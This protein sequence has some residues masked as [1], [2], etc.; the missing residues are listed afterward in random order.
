MTS[1]AWYAYLA[2]E[3]I[4]CTLRASGQSGWARRREMISRYGFRKIAGADC[5]NEGILGTA[6]F[7]VSD[8]ADFPSAVRDKAEEVIDSMVEAYEKGNGCRLR[9]ADLCL[10]ARVEVFRSRE[11]I[12]ISSIEAVIVGECGGEE[13]WIEGEYRIGRDDPLYGQF[14]EYFMGQMEKGLFT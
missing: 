4:L 2:M 1:S 3:D 11:N 10:E 8:S 9:M 13:V 12:P 7:P 5:F 6:Y 14:R